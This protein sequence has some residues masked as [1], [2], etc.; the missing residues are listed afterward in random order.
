MP[1]VYLVRHGQ[2]DTL[3][4]G[5]PGITDLGKRQAE[6]AAAELG[7]RGLR[8]PILMSGALRRQMDT[9][10]VISLSTGI[11][12]STP[13]E[14]GFNEFDHHAILLAHS[15]SDALEQADNR[16][17]Q[18]ALDRA[19]AAWI[20]SQGDEWESFVA[21]AAK[22]LDDAL[23]R[24]DGG[25]DLVIVTSGGVIAALCMRALAATPHSFVA[26]NRMAVNASITVLVAGS[27]GVNLLSYNDHAHLRGGAAELLTYR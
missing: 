21:G 13:A 27:R 26:L 9:A 3:A 14:P 6:T 8:R 5:D 1:T 18:A 15:E 24:A 22:A 25:Q 20:S 11:P 2:T 4:A 17:V 23:G 10:R 19:L 12:L 7:R 16:M